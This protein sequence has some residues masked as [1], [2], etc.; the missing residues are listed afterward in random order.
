VRPDVIEAHL[1]SLAGSGTKEGLSGVAS[2][3][4]GGLSGLLEDLAV[5]PL[6]DFTQ[7]L[8]RAYLELIDSDG[9][10]NAILALGRSAVSNNARPGRSQSR[11]APAPAPARVHSW[12]RASGAHLGAWEHLA[13]R[14]LAA[15]GV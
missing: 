7:A 4:P 12:S 13:H 5:L 15:S 10:R 8:V 11:R 14:D 1:A 6:R 3:L 9:S 2:G